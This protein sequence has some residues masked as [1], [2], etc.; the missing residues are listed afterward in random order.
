MSLARADWDE[1]S[2]DTPLAGAMFFEDMVYSE[3]GLGW[4]GSAEK[5]DQN[6]GDIEG[7]G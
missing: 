2:L 1:L 4:A 7:L 3:D 5:R 6:G